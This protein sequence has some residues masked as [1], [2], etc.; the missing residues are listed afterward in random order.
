LGAVV[1]YALAALVVLPEG[2]PSPLARLVIAVALL[3]TASSVVA[4]FRR[5]PD[6]NGVR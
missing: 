5:H 2:G 6:G 1:L 4:V 3:T